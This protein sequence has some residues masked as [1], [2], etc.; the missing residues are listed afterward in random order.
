MT[1]PPSNPPK[2]GQVSALVLAAGRGERLRPHTD[3]TPKPLLPVRGQP[4][5]AW[6]LQALAAAGVC[7]VVINTAWLEQQFEPTLGD[8]ARFGLAIT[9]SHEQR[10]HGQALETAGGIAKAL[11]WL[12][13]ARAVPHDGPQDAVFWV[14]SGD[15]FVPGFD[16]SPA[17]VQAFKKRPELDA[18]LWLA[19]NAAHHPQGDF[20]LDE[21]TGLIVDTE[22]TVAVNDAAERSPKRT[23]A[24]VGLFRARMFAHIAVGTRLPL[25]P[26]LDQAIRQGRLG[27]ARWDGTWV[28]VGT[29]ERWQSLDASS[30][31]A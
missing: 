12:R 27:G 20:R 5:I 1:V 23:W 30:A 24:S 2:Q 8:G 6:H 22:S 29:V 14:V 4:L 9:Y 28:D 15:V 19:P 31:K 25:R 13:E 3:H 11:P 18:W 7:Q 16:F 17:H 10:D 26:L 21:S